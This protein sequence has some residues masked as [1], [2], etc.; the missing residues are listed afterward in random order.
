MAPST[1]WIGSASPRTALWDVGGCGSALSVGS[2]LVSTTLGP[3]R[4]FG[5]WWCRRGRVLG[6]YVGCGWGWGLEL[7]AAR[8]LLELAAPRR[9]LELA[10]ARRLIVWQHWLRRWLARA[11]NGRHRGEIGNQARCRRWGALRCRGSRLGGVYARRGGWACGWGSCLVAGH[12]WGRRWVRCASGRRG[13][14]HRCALDW[15]GFRGWG[16]L[17]CGDR[18]RRCGRV[19]SCHGRRRRQ[20]RR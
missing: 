5:I 3:D 2:A 20:S 11:S 6:F 19:G 4:L 9:L 12:V 10:A 14:C 15:G 18:L 1:N 13:W 17:S 16:W 7:A 8:R